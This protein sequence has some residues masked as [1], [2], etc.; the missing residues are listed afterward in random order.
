MHFTKSFRAAM[1]L[2][3]AVVVFCGAATAVGRQSAEQPKTP[4]TR[5]APLYATNK[6]GTPAA[7]LTAAD[8]EVLVGGRPVEG[9]AL[10][11]GGSLNKLVFLVFDS[12]SISSNLL[13]KSKKIAQDTIS[14]ADSRVRFVVMGIDPYAGLRPICGPTADKELI[15]DSIARSVTAKRNEYFRSRATD[16]TAILDAYPNGQGR[17]PTSVTT[18]VG[19]SR[20]DLQEDRQVADVLITSLRTLN[21]VL[22]RFSESDKVVHLYSSGIPAGATNDYSQVVYPGDAISLPSKNAMSSPDRVIY[23]QIKSAGQSFRQNGAL[24]F[25]INPGGTRVGEDDVTSGEQSLHMLVNESGGRYF[26]GA[27]QDIIQALTETE[28]GYYQLSL[29]PLRETPDAEVEV[30]IHAKDP[31]ITLTSIGVLARTRKFALMS[32]QERQ[33]LILSVL[34]DGLIGDIGLKISR[35][36]VDIQSSGDEAQLTAQLPFD[37]SQS[38]WDIYK[39]WRGPGKGEVA[40]EK[41]HVL[42]DGPLLTFGMASRENAVQD[43]VLVHA[44]SGT[45]LVCQGKDAPKR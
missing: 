16:G 38:E 30:S 17:D 29:P 40:V 7:G 2:V 31:A 32:P 23:D 8:L 41:E 6:D 27:D 3:I 26:E 1:S 15:I 12:S 44:K 21:E 34:T 10:T 45:V 20:R 24:A 36:P 9:F 25:F 22:R 18:A 5:T 43:A 35:I 13:N 42:S 28:Q 33:G 37:L 19:E 11:K 14:K 4:G 39:V